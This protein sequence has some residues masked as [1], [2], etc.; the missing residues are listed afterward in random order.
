[1]YV[2]V[3]VYICIYVS[4]EVKIAF[5]IAHTR[6]NVVVLFGTLKVQFFILTEVSDCGLLIV[7]TSSTFLKKKDMLKEK[8]NLS[9]ISSHLLAY[10]YTCVLCT[11]I[12]IYVCRD[13][14]LFHLDSVSGRDTWP[15]RCLIPTPGLKSKYPICAVC[16]C[17]RIHT[18]TPTYTPTRVKIREATVKELFVQTDSD[19]RCE[20]A[21]IYEEAE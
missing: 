2:Y 9:R 8:S 14:D 13:S 10:M 4:S 1:M 7:V 19:L 20:V 16:V 5:I 11:H 18:H 15:S 21:R 12:R 6:N 17:V 3:C